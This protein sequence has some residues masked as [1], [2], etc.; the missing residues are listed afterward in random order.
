MFVVWT[1]YYSCPPLP[2]VHWDAD[3]SRDADTNVDTYAD[4]ASEY[5]MH[6]LVLSH[7]ISV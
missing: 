2:V 4:I 7:L 6:L 5:P 1:A 3:S